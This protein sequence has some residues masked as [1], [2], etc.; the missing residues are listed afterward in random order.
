MGCRTAGAEDL[1][2]FR[3]LAFSG[4]TAVGEV[5]R[6]RWDPA[7]HYDR[8]GRSSM[9]Y[10]TRGGFVDS[11][12]DFDPMFFGL[13]PRTAASMDPQQRLFLEVAWHTLEHAGYGGD[14][15][16]ARTGV[17]VGCEQNQYLQHFADGIR[18]ETCRA[19]FAREPALQALTP[20]ARNACLH[21]VEQA[22]RPAG[23][24]SDVV[25]GNGLNQIAARISHWLDLSGPA[26]AVNTA[27]SSGATALHTACQ[28]LRSGDCEMALVGGVHLNVGPDTFVLLSKMQALS[29]QGESRPFDAD[30]SGIVLGEG[31]GAVLLKRLGAARR[32][33]DRVHTVIRGSAVNND[34]RSQGLTAPNPAGQ[35][36]A[37]ARAW[38]D[39]GL[40]PATVN[41][42]EAHGTGTVLGDPIEV[43]GLR[44]GFERYT[45]QCRFCTLASLKAVIGHTLAASAILGVIRAALAFGEQ[46]IPPT[47]GYASPNPHIDLDNSPAVPGTPAG[48]A[49]EPGDEPRR[50][51]VSAFGFGGTN[52]HVVLEE[53]PVTSAGVVTPLDS[54]HL[55]CIS[56]RNRQQLAAIAHELMNRLDAVGPDAF[57]DLCA[58]QVLA[59]RRMY[60]R[61]SLVVRSAEELRGALAHISAGDVPRGAA[62]AASN[63]ARRVQVEID[64][65]RLVAPSTEVAERLAR[66][67]PVWGAGY[68]AAGRV[69]NGDAGRALA[70]AWGTAALMASIGLKPARVSAA[71]DA[72]AACLVGEI[73]LVEARRRL[74]LADVG[75]AEPN[76]P[77]PQAKRRPND[78]SGARIVFSADDGETIVPW[79]HPT[80]EDSEVVLLDALASAFR[81]GLPFDVRPLIPDG[82]GRADVALHPFEHQSYGP[83]GPLQ[84]DSATPSTG[85]HRPA[86]TSPNDRDTAQVSSLEDRVKEALSQSPTACSSTTTRSLQ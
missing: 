49:L 52:G 35:A 6:E 59:T 12:F 39:A 81:V 29:P 55:I 21:A 44:R 16:P 73:T 72:V 24:N 11:A 20:E 14:H 1:Y 62:A 28:S 36:D 47:P 38:E 71:D 25:P 60:Q 17:F 32:D 67:F 70:A 86:P 5:P 33:G 45:D 19:T 51:G 80:A 61:L 30:A 75:V 50:V 9:S 69:G 26:L 10:V 63:P 83:P 43:E 22:F 64:V 40:D 41:Y 42:V 23:L 57:A 56:G 58:S 13:S 7:I 8:D 76:P 53:G 77:F 27:C 15:R 65:G 18:F 3:E 37:I 79:P 84:A 54:A 31:A 85:P 46:R 2:A 68:E 34:G 66:R 48:G 82:V 74:G 4:R 78:G